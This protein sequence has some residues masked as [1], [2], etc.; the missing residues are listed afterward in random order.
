MW[1][2][3][4]TFYIALMPPGDLPTAMDLPMGST[5]TSA[6]P[7]AWPGG[8]GAALRRL[9]DYMAGAIESYAVFWLEIWEKPVKY[10][11]IYIELEKAI[12]TLD[13]WL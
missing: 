2:P 3:M 12:G 7:S 9:G 10:I 5:E 1:V 13:H 4:N 8:E 6:A 11:Y